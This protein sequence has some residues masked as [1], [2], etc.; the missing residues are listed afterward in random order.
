MLLNEYFNERID[1]IKIRPTEDD[2]KEFH[3]PSGS[4]YTIG[5]M[6]F[7]DILIDESAVSRTHATIDV[8]ENCVVITDSNSKNGTFVNEERITQKALEDG[9]IIRIGRSQFI[10]SFGLITL[11]KRYFSSQQSLFAAP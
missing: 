4:I 3:C 11:S 2:T 10:V 7:C 5:R 8:R 1:S 9:D 6:P